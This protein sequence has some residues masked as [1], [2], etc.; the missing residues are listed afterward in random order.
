MGKYNTLPDINI[1]DK[2]VQSW[3]ETID[4]MAKILNVPA[5]LI[6]RVHDAEIEVFVRSSNSENVY[7]KGEKAKLNT[8]L[9]CETVMDT[10]Q[11]L[12]V[13]D[14]FADPLW[15][16]NP[17]IEL[18]M[19]S[20]LGVPLMW[21]NGE[22]F[23]TVCVLDGKANSYSD[24]YL[25]L[26]NQFKQSVQLGLK[27]LFEHQKLLQVQ[28]QLVQSAK[29][30]SLGEMSACLAHELNQPLAVICMETEMGL[31]ELNQAEARTLSLIKPRFSK[32]ETQVER[33]TKIINHLRTFSGNDLKGKHELSDVN[34]IVGEALVL[35]EQTIK[36]GEI[37]LTLDLAD[38]P[39]KI[40]CDYIQIQ[41]VLTNL[42]SNACYALMENNEPSSRSLNIKSYSQA[43]N[44]IVTVEDNAGGIDNSKFEK[45]FDP[46]YTTKPPGKGTGLG[47]SISHGIISTHNGQLLVENIEQGCRFTMVLPTMFKESFDDK[48]T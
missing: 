13:P 12:I 23:G 5:G 44:V 36:N 43:D 34:W 24:L 29:L 15:D 20:Y 2:M 17:D 45:I 32:I 21:P 30:A 38:I 41:Q 18:N 28:G 7:E 16:K 1:P 3:Q 25:E 48:D 40:E 19:I 37:R 4:I 46:F 31:E 10:Q 27:T 11:P 14:A 22:V 33:C 39:P 47:L 9:Y 35:F 8:G 26:V 42:V 6:M